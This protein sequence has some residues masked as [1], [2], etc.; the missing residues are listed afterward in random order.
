MENLDKLR[1]R[2]GILK[3][4]SNNDY[5]VRNAY[6]RAVEPQERARHQEQMARRKTDEKQ[7]EINFTRSLAQAGLTESSEGFNIYSYI[8][9]SNMVFGVE[10]GFSVTLDRIKRLIDSGVFPIEDS[11]IE[12]DESEGIR[13]N[14]SI[15]YQ[16][17]SMSSDLPKLP[18]G[19]GFDSEY[20]PS[21]NVPK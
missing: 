14:F 10:Y 2:A 15:P 12:Y 3:E 13:V 17:Q 8:D 9:N 7:A 20:G 4:A 16:E 1:R 5:A 21:G 6:A 11:Q 18:S 19:A